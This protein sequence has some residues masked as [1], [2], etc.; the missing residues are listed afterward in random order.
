M[1]CCLGDDGQ[2]GATRSE[3]LADSDYVAGE[4]ETSELAKRAASLPWSGVCRGAAGMTS[5]AFVTKS[6]EPDRARCELLCR[7]I[8]QLAPGAHHWIIVDARDRPA[9]RSLEG[10]STRVIT[11][12]ELLPRRAWK[13]DLHGLGIDKNI[14]LSRRT[15]PMRGWLVQQLAKLAI[16][17]VADEDVLIHADSDVVLFRPFDADVLRGDGQSF[18][19]YRIPAVVDERLPKH[20]RWHRTAERLLG[21][22]RRPLPLPDYI[23]G[24][25]PWRRDVVRALL[26]EIARGSRR[27]WVQALASARELSEYILYGRFVDDLLGKTSGSPPQCPSLCHCYWGSSPITNSALDEFIGASAP[28]EIGVMVS[29]VAGMDPAT[30]AEVFERRWREAASERPRAQLVPRGEVSDS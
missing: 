30:Y 22:E 3:R 24:L 5:I 18:P 17:R 14:W 21:L 11:T 10:P 26:D 20:V 27:D 2:Q 28:S 1:A 12:E 6:Y 7:S 19:L 9:F 4:A 8:E 13:L 23:G 25:V 29:A 16:S 15:R